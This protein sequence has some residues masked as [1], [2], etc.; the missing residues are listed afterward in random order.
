MTTH[1]ATDTHD[2]PDVLTAQAPNA[3]QGQALWFTGLPGCGKSA[4]ARAVAQA[5]AERGEEAVHLELD[6]LRKDWFPE[7]DYSDA[8]R[9]AAYARFVDEAATRAAAGE[10]V[11]MDATAMRRRWRDAARQRMERFTE[12][13]LDCPLETAMAREAARPEGK[14]MADLYE[15]ALL[16]RATG[17]AVEGLG[18]V[19]GVDVPYEPSEPEITLDAATLSVDDCRDMVLAY[20]GYI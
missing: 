4:V 10:L 12:I 3:G 7:P 9:E 17:Q 1:E 15:K 5:L 16:R 18:P 2:G 8:E 19:P 14:V 20:A 11:L 13:Y 6:A